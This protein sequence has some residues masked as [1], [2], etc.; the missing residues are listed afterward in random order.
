MDSSPFKASD[1]ERFLYT[2]FVEIKD[3]PLEPIKEEEHLSE[4][5]DE[6]PVSS[7]I[8]N[9]GNDPVEI[10]AIVSS[11]QSEGKHPRTLR[12]KTVGSVEQGSAI[13]IN[14]PKKKDPKDPKVD[15]E[16]LEFYKRLVCEI[17]DPEKMQA[18]EPAIEYSNLKDLNRHMRKLHG[19][20]MGHVKCPM[21]D[22]KFRSRIKLLEHKD[23]HLNPDR[24]RCNQ[25]NEIY[26]NMEEHVK[27]KHQERAYCCEDCGKR[28]PTKSR[29]TAHIRKMHTAKDVICD[30]CQKP[31][32]K[33][34]IKDHKRAVHE[35]SFMCELCPRTFKARLPLEQHL[36]E[37][38]TGLRP[39][40]TATCN[41]CGTVVRDKY[42]LSTHIKRLHTDHPPVSCG[43]CGK[44]FKSK[45]NLGVH[46]ANVC[47]DR[48]FPCTI[49]GK[50]FKKKIKLTEHMTT[51]TRSALYQCQYCPKTFSF[52][53]QLYTHRK[54]VHHEQWLELQRRRKQGERFKAKRIAD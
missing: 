25:C 52:E 39:A 15:K 27:N 18:G 20:E 36:E 22:K 7:A 26:Q 37:H 9:L 24:F 50:Q 2:E 32:S 45:H 10:G 21:C 6:K 35:A 13:A 29:L 46:L 41:I 38:K 44:E 8:A 43:S 33:Y 17:C 4:N 42:C 3:E 30:L 11:I 16:I 53:T 48:S 31:F 1:S 14:A 47:T 40:P 19:Q 51:H 5:A 23:M 49:C 28:F 12:S 34:T 54:Q